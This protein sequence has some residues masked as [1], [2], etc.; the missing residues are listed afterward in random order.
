ML[1]YPKMYQK[2]IQDINYDKLKEIG[3][4]CLVFDLDNTIALIDQKIITDDVKKFLND[5]KKDFT[6]IIISNNTKKRV[7]VY[8]DDLEC[9]FIS[10][11]AKPIFRGAK[12]LINKCGYNNN[13]VAVIGDQLVTDI[14]G[15][16]LKGYY[17]ILVDPLAKKD[18]KITTV[19]RIIEN[20]ILKKYEKKKVMKKGEYYG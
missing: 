2:K 16:N 19:N 18:L 12:K 7:K 13:E 17:P 11:A 5:L 15:S 3:I 1:F 20:Q 14:F 4:K 10:S 9:Y 8:A 6:V